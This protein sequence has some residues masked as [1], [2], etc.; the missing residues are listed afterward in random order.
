[1]CL[2]RE[3]AEDEKWLLMGMGFLL[4]VI[5]TLKLDCSDDCTILWIKLKILNYTLQMGPFM[6]YELYVNEV[7]YEKVKKNQRLINLTESRWFQSSY[8]F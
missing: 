6:V 1:M 8:T 5:I 3:G 2:P 7:V 4:R